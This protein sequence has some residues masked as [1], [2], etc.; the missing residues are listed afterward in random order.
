MILILLFVFQASDTFTV[1]TNGS[2]RT[3]VDGDGRLLVATSSASGTHKLQVNGSAQIRVGE[4]LILQ[5]AAGSAE[6]SIECA[7]AGS[8]TDI[9]IRTNSTERAKVTHAGN[10]GIGTDNPQVKLTVSSDSPA[11]CDIHH[12]DGGTDDEARLILGALLMVVHLPTEV[13]VCFCCK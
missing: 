11:V 5:N 1:H 4:S 2:E 8:N 6:G 10:V 3:R 13:L 9:R 12:I 7:G